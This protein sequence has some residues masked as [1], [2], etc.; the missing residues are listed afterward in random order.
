[1]SGSIAGDLALAITGLVA[2]MYGTIVGAGGGFILVPLL[3]LARADLS[4]ASVTTISLGAVFF[5]ACSGA[6]AYA[7][8]K[9]IDYKTGLLFALMTVP[10]AALG[11]LVVSRVP[12]G[13]FQLLFG[14]FLVLLAVF[15]FIRPGIQRQAVQGARQFYRTLR[16]SKGNVYE[17]SYPLAVGMSVSFVVGFLAALLGVGGGIMLVPVMVT[18]LAFPPPV[19]TAT[20]SFILL[21]TSVSASITHVFHGDFAGL[22]QSTALAAVGMIVGAQIGARISQ[23]MSGQFIV[24]LLAVALAFVGGRLILGGLSGG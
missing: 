9:R 3:L 23:R 14:T 24:R 12:R 6:G 10:T 15:I 17:W 11:A 21:F 2:G 4:A 13:P 19:A 7:R 20:S 16:D 5:N 22:E 8:Q 1:V 18:F